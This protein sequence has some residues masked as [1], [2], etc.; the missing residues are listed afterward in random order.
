MTFFIPIISEFADRIVEYLK[1]M[2]YTHIELM[3]IAEYPYDGSWGYQVTIGQPLPVLLPII[4][5]QHGRYCIY[6]DTVNMIFSCP[7]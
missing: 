4:Q 1:E 5:I 2:R 7:E 6:P 3:G